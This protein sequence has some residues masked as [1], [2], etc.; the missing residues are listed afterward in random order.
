MATA[1]D[2][3]RHQSHLPAQFRSNLRCWLQ[4]HRPPAPD[5]KLA[6]SVSESVGQHPRYAMLRAPFVH[7]IQ[8]AVEPMSAH[9]APQPHH[10]PPKGVASQ[11]AK[12]TAVAAHD[13]F[14]P[15]LVLA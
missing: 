9:Q 2:A 15:V 11:H 10:Q 8:K 13:A 14:V 7:A 6:A 3:K 5:P 4:L 1:T 12:W